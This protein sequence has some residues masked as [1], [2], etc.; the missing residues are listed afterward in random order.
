VAVWI[1]DDPLEG[2]GNPSADADGAVMLQA[3]AFGSGQTERGIAATV[4]H[5]NPAAGGA[6][7]PGPAGIRIVTWREKR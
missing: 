2:D 4:A 6:Y 1:A 5:D 3:R 7:V